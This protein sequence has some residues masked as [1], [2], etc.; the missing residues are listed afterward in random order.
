MIDD[1]F[2]LPVL[3][4]EYLADTAIS[5]ARKRAFLLDAADGRPRL[6]ALLHELALVARRTRPYVEGPEPGNLVSF[7]KRDSTHWRSASWRDSDAGYAGG[8]FAMDVNAIWVPHA[9]DATA[10]ILAKLRELGFGPERLDSIAPGIGGTPLG[11]YLRDP[12]SLARAVERWRGA[13]RHFE[14]ALGPGDIRKH[15]RARLGALPPEER[16]FWETLTEANG[17]DRDSLGFLV[18][19]LDTDGRPIPVVNT[20]P[21]TALFLDRAASEHAVLFN[22]APIMRPFPV[23]LFVE[24]L[25]PVVANDAFAPR[26][27]WE[28]FEKDRYHSPRVVWG[29]EVNLLLLGLANQLARTSGPARE[30]LEEGLRRTLAAVNASGLQH[31]ELWSY[32]IENGKLVPTRYGT[33]SDLQLWSST[34]LAVQFVL[35]RLPPD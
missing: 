26:R 20:D 18:L 25:G 30:T 7:P 5:D 24:G 3:A 6:A 14:V 22:L 2:Q 33:S 28:A 13:R 35:S 29:R 17:S 10:G 27:V 16:R 19:S 34:S 15:L 31:N 23:G 9:L 1:E 21:A 12:P 8:R 32:R 11:G 4:A